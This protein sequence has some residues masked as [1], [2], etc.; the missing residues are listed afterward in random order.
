MR[1]AHIVAQAALLTLALGI[2]GCEKE[3]NAPPTGGS[4]AAPGNTDGAAAPTPPTGLGH[5]GTPIELGTTTIGPFTVRAARDEGGINAGG[6]API[7]VWL[8]G[9]IATVTAVR[10]WIGDEDAQSSIKA[11]ADI[12]DPAQPNHWHTHAEVPN[13][14]PAGSML[15][16]EIETADGANQVGSF[17]LKE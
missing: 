13:P 8:E 11:R 14:M 15:W 4:P 7:D 17:D 2:A 6:D 12:E 1:I 3:E 5:H 16:V 9:D 10:F